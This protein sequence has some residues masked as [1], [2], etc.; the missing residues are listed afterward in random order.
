MVAQLSVRTSL[1]P[2][3]HF[4]MSLLVSV[5]RIPLLHLLPGPAVAFDLISL[6]PS[7]SSVHLLSLLQPDISF[8]N[9]DLSPSLL[10]FKT[11]Q[12]LLRALRR[13]EAE[14]LGLLKLF[15]TC[16]LLISPAA[17]LPSPQLPSSKL[18]L[19]R[20]QFLVSAQLFCASSL[21]MC[22]SC[23]PLFSIPLPANSSPS[24]KFQH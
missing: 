6:L 17:S 1:V 5:P 8:S 9:S 13:D 7:P 16:S 2:L 19:N 15:V 3:S 14:T 22:S 12:W 4:P 24:Y 11:P 10:Y 23:S 18:Q 20:P 21:C